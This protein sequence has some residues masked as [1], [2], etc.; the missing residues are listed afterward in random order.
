MRAALDALSHM[1]ATRKIAVLGDMLELGPE[2][3]WF[4]RETGRYARGR[5]DDLVC[6]GSRARVIAEGALEEGFDPDH[7]RTVDT[8]EEAAALLPG[9]LQEGTT[10]L[11]KASRGVGLERAVLALMGRPS[12]G[13]R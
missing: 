8:P 10:I 3:S 13:T 4:H 1:E 2:E 7:I 6:V 11:F 12:R 5:A 9:T